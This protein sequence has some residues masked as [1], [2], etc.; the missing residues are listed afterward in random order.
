[1]MEQLCGEFHL[2]I[3]YQFAAQPGQVE[4]GSLYTASVNRYR[5]YV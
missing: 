4:R 5:Q 2:P 3:V 1:M